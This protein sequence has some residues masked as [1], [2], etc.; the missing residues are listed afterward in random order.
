MF[1]VLSTINKININGF[2]EAKYFNS[3][4]G[5]MYVQKGVSLQNI[6][7]QIRQILSYNLYF[8]LDIC[9]AHPSILANVCD[10]FNINC[11]N[12]IKYR[13]HRDKCINDLLKL[14]HHL[15]RSDIKTL[16]I[17]LMN[18]GGD[19][20]YNQFKVKNNFIKKF[21]NETLIISNKIK[22]I[23]PE[24]YDEIFKTKNRR[25]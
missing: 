6:Q 3:K 14:N 22:E 4:C 21:A 23:R 12:I 8:D 25:Q 17:A 9:N 13:D 20:Y 19:Y 2:Y 16:L 10:D 11:P 1:N 24:Q 18:G 15:N 7:K 5:R